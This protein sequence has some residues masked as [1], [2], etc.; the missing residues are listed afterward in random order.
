MRYLSVAPLFS[1]RME[2]F[3]ENKK[4]RVSTGVTIEVNDN[5]DT[6]VARID[7]ALFVNGFYSLLDLMEKTEKEIESYAQY[8]NER[9]KLEFITEK[10]KDIM[11]QIDLLFGAET[12]E[13]VFC[14][15]IPSGYA[16]ADFFD[17][18]V[19]IFE[20]YADARQK[21]IAEKY[22]RG[23]KGSKSNYN[24]RPHYHGKGKR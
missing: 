21:K 5:G 3:M 12:C 19:P 23:R 2:I 9:E 6:I 4:I 17:Q 18:L 11:A 16:L 10:T 24:G 7:D 14:G 13:K 22:N 15:A 20:G 8:E 1:E